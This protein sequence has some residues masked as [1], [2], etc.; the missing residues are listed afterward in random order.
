MPPPP[1]KK[2]FVHYLNKYLENSSRSLNKGKFF[3]DCGL[4]G[5]SVKKL[6]FKKSKGDI[7]LIHIFIWRNII[8]TTLELN[9][10]KMKLKIESSTYTVC[11]NDINNAFKAFQ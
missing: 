1:Q 8:K 5:D 6:C 4:K 11:N 2:K 7:K 10:K 9:D 3:K